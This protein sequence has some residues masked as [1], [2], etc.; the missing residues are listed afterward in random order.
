V[1]LRLTESEQV[2]LVLGAALI[3]DSLDGCSYA[4]HD[5]LLLRRV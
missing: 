5:R 4:A 1:A 3:S 2:H